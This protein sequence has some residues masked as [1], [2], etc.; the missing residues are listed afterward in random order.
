MAL[1][2]KVLN[3]LEENRC[4][5]VSGNKI[6]TSLGLTRSAVWKAVKQ[7][8]EEGYAIS[9]VTNRGYCLTDDNDIL[10]EPAVLSRLTT[11]ELGRNMDIFKTIDST[12]NFAKSL[13]HLGAVHGYAIISESQTAGRGR[14]GKKFYSPNNQG[15]YLSVILRPDISIDYVLLIT[16]CAAVAVAE[17]IENVSGLKCGIKWVNDIYAEGK[18]ICGI[19]TEASIGVEQSGVDYVV[20]GIGINTSTASFPEDIEDKASS[21]RLLTGKNVSRSHLVAEVLN[22]LEKR[23]DNLTSRDFIAEYRRRSILINKKIIIEQGEN[24]E[25]V[26]CKDIDELGRLIVLDSE[27]NKKTVSSGSVVLAE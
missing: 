20:L 11:R 7:L 25:I 17:A 3:I 12:N 22:C 15:I 9:A 10:N 8:R 19:L 24:S 13:A 18:K 4:K 23:L 21:I 26:R 2:D 14:Q 5:S 6:A 1:K 16:S 27:G